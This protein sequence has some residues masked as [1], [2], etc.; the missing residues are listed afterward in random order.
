MRHA[1]KVEHMGAPPLGKV[2]HSAA[3]DEAQSVRRKKPNPQ[4]HKTT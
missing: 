3:D 2:S 1:K 4:V